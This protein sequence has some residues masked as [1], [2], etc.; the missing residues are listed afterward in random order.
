M[1]K[2]SIYVP[3]AMYDEL[4]RRHLPASQIAQAAFSKALAENA[5][6]AW[7]ERMLARPIN[8]RITTSTEDLMD[9]VDE[10]FEDQ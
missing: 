5:N 3:D 6:A 4:R 10:E 9:A 1:P 8:D 2:I 7:I